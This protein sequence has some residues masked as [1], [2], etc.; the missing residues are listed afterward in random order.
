MSDDLKAALELAIERR[1]L[2]KEVMPPKGP[3]PP[4]PHKYICL[5]STGKWLVRIKLNGRAIIHRRY[6]TLEE[7]IEVRDYTLSKGYPPPAKPNGRPR[8]AGDRN[9]R[10]RFER[11]ADKGVDLLTLLEAQ[12]P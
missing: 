12:E 10:R 5:L 3:R 1:R 2:A 11:I 4:N 8:R 7:A 6:V 9:S